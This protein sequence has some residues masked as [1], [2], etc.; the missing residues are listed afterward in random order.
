MSYKGK[1]PNTQLHTTTPQIC[2][3]GCN[4][5]PTFNAYLQCGMTS[6]PLAIISGEPTI[7]QCIIDT[8]KAKKECI[9]KCSK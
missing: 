9:D 7:A 3:S 5:N 1:F 4:T 6:V 2:T 8:N